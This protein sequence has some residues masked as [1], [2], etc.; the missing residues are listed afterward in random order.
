MEVGWQTWRGNLQG[1]LHGK[2]WRWRRLLRL[3]SWWEAC[4]EVHEG[5]KIHKNTTAESASQKRTFKHNNLRRTTLKSLSQLSNL[6][7]AASPSEYSSGWGSLFLVPQNNTMARLWRFW[8]GRTCW[9]NFRCMESSRSSIPTLAGHLGLEPYPAHSVIGHGLKAMVSIW[10]AIC[11]VTGAWK[12]VLTHWVARIVPT[13]HFQILRCWA[14]FQE[15]MDLQISGSKVRKPG[16]ASTCA[17][18][19]AS[20][21]ACREK[22][23]TARATSKLRLTPCTGRSDSR[24]S[25]VRQWW[26]CPYIFVWA[27]PACEHEW[28]KEKRVLWMSVFACF[29]CFLM[30]LR[31][32]HVC[33]ASQADLSMFSVRMKWM[34]RQTNMQ[35]PRPLTVYPATVGGSSKMPMCLDVTSAKWLLSKMGKLFPTPWN[36]LKNHWKPPF[37]HH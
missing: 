1:G 12:V 14:K 36:I 22:S 10:S 25:R 27:T 33:G 4:A 23:Q 20:H 11:K 24:D 2:G 30:S 7:V 32:W 18:T 3:H 5:W 35:R 6:N 26:Q 29:F 17:M 34:L 31:V 37:N 8:R 28:T 15:H 21:W 9:L 16:S 13:M 19:F